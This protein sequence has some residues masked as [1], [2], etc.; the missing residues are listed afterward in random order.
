MRYGAVKTSRVV[1][2]YELSLDQD[3]ID[4]AI[5]S[6]Y[7]IPEQAKI[8]FDFGYGL[9]DATVTWDEPERLV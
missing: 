2:S 9:V 8:K 3:Q 4:T 7:D 6:F 1:E 5:R